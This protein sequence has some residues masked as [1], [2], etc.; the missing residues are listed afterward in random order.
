LPALFG[1]GADDVDA[2]AAKYS[3]FASANL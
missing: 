1:E 2:T 3:G